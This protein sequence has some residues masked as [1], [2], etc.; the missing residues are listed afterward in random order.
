MRKLA[1]F[2]LAT[3]LVVPTAL[4]AQGGP[5]GGRMMMRNP[6]AIAID[7]K[8]DLQ[9]TDDQVA[10]LTAIEKALTEKNAPVR[11][12]MQQLRQGVDFQSMTDEQRQEMRQKAMPLM[13][14][15]RA[16]TDAARANAEKLLKPEQVTKL[17]EI[18][19]QEMPQRG[20]RP[21]S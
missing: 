15:M 17:Q 3:A 6:I 4:S 5:G 19:Q 16:N 20:P 9:L 18:L 13:Q 1:G 7:H 10:K 8:S 11:E 2:L 21:N 12:K 14:E